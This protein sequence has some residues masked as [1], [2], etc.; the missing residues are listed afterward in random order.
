MVK[1]GGIMDKQ[2]LINRTKETL[3][4][5]Q[6]DHIISYLK[7]LT[8]ERAMENPWLIAAFIIIFFYAVVKRSKF[9]LLSLFTVISLM[10]LIRYTFPAGGGEMALSST[11]PFVFGALLIGAVVLYFNFIKSE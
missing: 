8:L 3:V 5:F 9:V 7:S 1:R 6:T 11:L 4:P 2:E 10:V